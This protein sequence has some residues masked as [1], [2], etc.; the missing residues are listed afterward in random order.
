[1]TDEEE[2]KTEE[3]VEAEPSSEEPEAEPVQAESDTEQKEKPKAEAQEDDTELSAEEKTSRNVMVIYVDIN[4]KER[5]RVY[6]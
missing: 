3:A 4:R 2:V 6:C 5:R 1:M